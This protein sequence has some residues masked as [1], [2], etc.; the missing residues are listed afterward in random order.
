M[1]PTS[2]FS[3]TKTNKDGRP[4]KQ[5]KGWG[6]FH[7]VL[8]ERSADFNLTLDVQNLRQEVQNLTNLRDV[9]CTQSIVKRDSPEGSLSRL[10][11]EYFHVFR[12]GVVVQEPGCKRLVDNRDQLAFMYSMMDE[13]VDMGNSLCGPDVWMEQM[14]LYSQF[15]RF[16]CMSAKV[17]SI[18]TTDDTVM[19]SVRGSLV[20]EVLRNTI[21]MI[22]P[23]ILGNEWLVAQLVGQQVEAPARSTFHFNSA[24][25]CFKYDV[26]MDY[27][28]AFTNIIKDPHIVDILLGKALI[29]D[30]AMLGIVDE[31]VVLEE[32]EKAAPGVV[33]TE[34]VDDHSEKENVPEGVSSKPARR[35]NNS[36]PNELFRRIVKEYFSVFENGYQG[37]K[38]DKQTPSEVAQRDFLLHRF[39]SAKQVEE[40][41]T[42]KYVERRWRALSECFEVFG[43]QQKGVASIE[44]GS[45][46]MLL[47]EASARYILRITFRT[48]ESVFPHLVSNKPLLNTLVG[49]VIKVP[50]QIVFSVKVSTRRISR[51]N[52]KMEFA[53]AVAELLPD[54][55]EL[56][57]VI[58]GALLTH[59]GV[60]FDRAELPYTVLSE[61]QHE[62]KQ[63]A[64]SEIHEENKDDS[65]STSRS[66][67]LADILS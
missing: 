44:R 31:P 28:S 6:R 61:P 55:V 35:T 7:S 20:F 64:L 39:A 63:Q 8:R 43:F 13:Q 21:V 10:V 51:I 17:H 49:K 18:V 56:S 22:F 3:K 41:T 53:S 36:D 25:K 52:E 54:S 45:S 65:D 46:N 1:Q 67:S 60:D 47:I 23:H 57:Y 19:I 59:D 16:I 40:E 58:S 24:G 14:A 12:K 37:A 30:N 42:A 32:E 27:V 33:D 9:L 48:I 66:M 62:E 5:R 15:L 50:S 29:A 4:R 38:T 11:N 26:D 34:S 2:Y